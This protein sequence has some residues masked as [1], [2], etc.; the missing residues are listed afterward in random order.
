MVAGT[1]VILQPSA[2]QKPQDVALDAVVDGDDVELRR[3]LPPKAFFP[4]PRRFVPGEALARCHHRHQVHAFE[5]GPFARLFFQPVQVELAVSRVRDHGVGHA[6]LADQ[7]GQRAGID[8]GKPDD[9]ACLQPLIEMPRGAVVRRVGDGGAQDHAARARR[10]RHV[11]RLD[12]LVV[13][14]DIADMREGEGDELPGIGGIG[15]D[16]LIAG[17]RGVE[18]D[19]ADRLAFRAE[20][21]TLQHG[22]IGKHE[23]RG[24]F[25]IR[26]G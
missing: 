1:T 23:E 3:G 12:V 5:A 25:V 2:G 22:A 21:E 11:H 10:R 18:A 19:F 9:A 4:L 15:E 8:A 13:G 26:P 7:R 14:A 6:A 20:A 24:R 17:H 16:L